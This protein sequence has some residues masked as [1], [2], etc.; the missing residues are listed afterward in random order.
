M[1]GCH[2][3]P[4][5]SSLR[6]AA[7]EPVGPDSNPGCAPP[8]PTLVTHL[9]LNQLLCEDWVS[10]C[11]VLWAGPDKYCRLSTCYSHSSLLSSVVTSFLL[12]TPREWGEIQRE[13]VNF[14]FP[15][16]TQSVAL[17]GVSGLSVTSGLL[18]ALPAP[19]GSDSPPQLC[20]SLLLPHA[21]PISWFSVWTPTHVST[22]TPGEGGPLCPG[23]YNLKWRKGSLCNF[24]LKNLHQVPLPS[25]EAKVSLFGIID[26]VSSHWKALFSVPGTQQ[27]TKQS[28]YVDGAHILVRETDNKQIDI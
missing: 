21:C 17:S 7:L 15:P 2:R 12:F 23:W 25:G 8:G 19:P 22:R 4:E 1:D 26:W 28:I 24:N 20:S 14:S 11:E 10:P 6:A 9:S 3:R 13:S 18:P 5:T 16:G 27:W